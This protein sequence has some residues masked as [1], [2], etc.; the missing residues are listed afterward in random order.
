VGRRDRLLA[1]LSL[2]LLGAGCGGA[3]E[4][5]TGTL[6]RAIPPALLADHPDLVTDV[7]CREPI[8]RG[9]GV[10]NTCTASVGGTPVELEVTQLDDDG[11]V[12]VSL[13]RPLL[14][15]DDLAARIADRLTT[16]V[17]VPTSVLCEGPAVRVL[18]VDE[19][20]RCAA[21]DPDDRTHTF[22]A[23]ILDDEANYDLRLE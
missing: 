19:A 7:S 6:E 18:T 11:Q 3:D 16:D 9:V 4:V 14:D 22:V 17:G 23:T 1:G 2:V 10:L 21:T 15:V 5:D 13:D 20:I 8:E 12:R